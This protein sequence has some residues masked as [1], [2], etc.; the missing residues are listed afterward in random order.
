MFLTCL[1]GTAN[2]GCIGE[3]TGIDYGC[4]D[5]VI[6]SC[7]FNESLSCSTGHG[8]IIGADNIT[9]DG[10]DNT[11]D[12]VSSGA[13]DGPGIHRSGIYNKAHEDVV[14]KNLGGCPTKITA[15][16]AKNTATHQQ[17]QRPKV[18]ES[19]EKFNE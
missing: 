11:L 6:E 3:V 18:R 5:T 19:L 17:N 16:T 12:G 8:L 7:A 4:G 10:N 9:I 15:I 2:A 1:I 13:C 14:I